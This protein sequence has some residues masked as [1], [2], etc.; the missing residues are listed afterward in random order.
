MNRY[1]LVSFE[2]GGMAQVAP[3]QAPPLHILTAF[4]LR[5]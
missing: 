5:C 3:H 1:R 4:G 2:L